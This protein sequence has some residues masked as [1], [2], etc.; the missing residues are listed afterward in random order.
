M[1]VTGQRTRRFEAVTVAR[2]SVHAIAM[3]VVGVVVVVMGVGSEG[4]IVQV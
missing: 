1:T 3:V 2:V 4:A